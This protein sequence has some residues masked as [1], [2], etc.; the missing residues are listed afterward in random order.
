MLLK[1]SA[2]VHI[3]LETPNR[4]RNYFVLLQPKRSKALF[5]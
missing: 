5:K 4:F 2:K 1:T 3:L